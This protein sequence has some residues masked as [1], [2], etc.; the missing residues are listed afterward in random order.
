MLGAYNNIYVKTILPSH[1]KRITNFRLS[2]HTWS[3]IGTERYVGVNENER[4]RRKCDCNDKE[5]EFHVILQC[6][7]YLDINILNL[8]IIAVL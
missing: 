8:F 6:P 1:T 2:S 4:I 3:I 7:L 5:A